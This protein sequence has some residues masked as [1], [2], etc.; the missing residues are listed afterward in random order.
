MLLQLLAQVLGLQFEALVLADEALGNLDL[1]RELRLVVALL[2]LVLRDDADLPVVG[3]EHV[4]VV[5]EHRGQ[6]DVAFLGDLPQGLERVLVHPEGDRLVLVA[7]RC[8]IY[9]T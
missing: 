9:L 1:R 4:D 3:D 2:D 5:T 8:R 6:R 7:H